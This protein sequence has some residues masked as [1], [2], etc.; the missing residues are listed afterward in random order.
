MEFNT[1]RLYTTVFDIDKPPRPYKIN[2]EKKRKKMAE[3]EKGLIVYIIIS[4]D[5]NFSVGIGLA[6]LK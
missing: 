6:I 5:R 3:K 1:R 4:M 2:E